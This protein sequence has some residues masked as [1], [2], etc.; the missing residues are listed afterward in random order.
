MENNTFIP[1][2]NVRGFIMPDFV[3]DAPNIS[4]GAKMLYALLCSY[5]GEKDYC[6]PSKE[7]LS[8]RLQCSLNTVKS[9]LAQ[10]VQNGLLCITPCP[11]KKHIS[12]FYLLCPALAKRENKTKVTCQILTPRLS[13]IDTEVNLNEFNIN[14]KPPTPFLKP[15]AASRSTPAPQIKAGGCVSDFDLTTFEEF[16]KVYP[17]K[18]AKELAKKMWLN[19]LHQKKLPKL[20]VLKVNLQRFLFSPA[21][22]KEDGRYIPQLVNWLRG[23]RWLD[24]ERE[25]KCKEHLQSY[26]VGIFQAKAPI[27]TLPKQASPKTLEEHL[28]EKF[29]KNFNGFEKEKAFFV[30]KKLFQNG[31]A[32]TAFDSNICNTASIMRY[33]TAYEGKVGLEV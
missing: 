19:L 33:L 24:E 8:K 14:L 16:W 3:F 17:R 20:D 26:I 5:A 28:F 7:T 12:A 13:K 4:M 15:S 21:W 29:A 30:W 9:Y 10:L 22:Q 18:E 2:G 23:E 1:K 32:P 6:W 27:T 31:N 11:H 25:E